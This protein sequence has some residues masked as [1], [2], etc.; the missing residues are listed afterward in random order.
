MQKIN[1]KHKTRRLWRRRGTVPWDAG[2]VERPT[3]PRQVSPSPEHS[4]LIRGNEHNH[5]TSRASWWSCAPRASV[6]L[7]PQVLVPFKYSSFVAHSPPT[8]F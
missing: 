6:S 5:T 7:V 2:G 1:Y 3:C 8:P 4:F